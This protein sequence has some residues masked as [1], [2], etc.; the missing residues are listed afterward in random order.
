MMRKMNETEARELMMLP[1]CWD[2]LGLANG[3]GQPIVDFDDY[4]HVVSTGTGP[5]LSFPVTGCAWADEVELIP[6]DSDMVTLVS[7]PTNG[8]S[9]R[10]QRIFSMGWLDAKGISNIRVLKAKALAQATFLSG[11]SFRCWI[12]AETRRKYSA[13]ADDDDF[14]NHIHRIWNECDT[15]QAADREFIANQLKLDIRK[16]GQT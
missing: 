2:K 5:A 13:L 3:R 14:R 4:L 8:G 9:R 16:W 10:W 6:V 15:E 12:E 11:V 1:E 7:F